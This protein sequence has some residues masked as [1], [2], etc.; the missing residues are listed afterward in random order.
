MIGCNVGFV[1]GIVCFVF[2]VLVINFVFWYF[3]GYVVFY[4]WVFFDLVDLVYNVWLLGNIDF[5]LFLF[6]DLWID[7]N[8]GNC[9]C[10]FID[11]RCI[12][13]FFV[14]DGS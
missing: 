1:F 13:N 14:K 6:F 8:I 12:F 10:V 7:C 2:F 4:I 3:I 9:K 11:K 5:I